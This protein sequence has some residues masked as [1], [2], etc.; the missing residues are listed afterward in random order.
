MV[1]KDIEENLSNYGVTS[2]E[3][4]KNNYNYDEYKSYLINKKALDIIIEN[5]NIVAPS[6]TEDVTE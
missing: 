5:A 6:S 3:E 4:F 2:V 1:E